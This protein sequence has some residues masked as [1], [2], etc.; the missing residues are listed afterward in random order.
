MIIK[1]ARFCQLILGLI[2][3]LWILLFVGY[4]LSSNYFQ[5]SQDI[6]NYVVIIILIIAFHTIWINLLLTAIIS[7]FSRKFVFEKFSL[8]TYIIGCIGLFVIISIDS[9]KYLEKLFD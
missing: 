3:A 5:A 4:L 7:I 6:F 2:P 1:V 8:I 9:G